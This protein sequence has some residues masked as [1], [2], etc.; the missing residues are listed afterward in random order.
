[1]TFDDAPLIPTTALFRAAMV[2]PTRGNKVL[3]RLCELGE[4]SLTHTPTGRD[5]LS[6]RD[7]EKAFKALSEK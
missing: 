1:M 3:D 4:I 5:F 6:P 2:S 7:G